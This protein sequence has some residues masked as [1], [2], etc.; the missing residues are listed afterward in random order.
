MSSRALVVLLALV[1]AGCGF[2]MRGYADVPFETLYV[3]DTRSG[4]GL[5]LKRVLEAGTSARVVSDARQ[6]QAVLELSNEYRAREILSLTAA[7]S[8][9]EYL[10]RYRVTYRVHDGKGGD[11]IPPSAI[12]LVRDMTYQDALA[13]AK[14]HE[15]QLLFR[16]MQSEAVQMILRRMSAAQRPQPKAE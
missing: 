5:E 13:L 3:Q 14:E 16:D 1:L 2:R 12:N 10:L 7:G 11:F 8:V 6:A 9:R 4:V 15:E